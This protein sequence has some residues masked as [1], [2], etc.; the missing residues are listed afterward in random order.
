MFHVTDVDEDSLTQM[1][2]DSFLYERL[3]GGIELLS[4]HSADECRDSGG[5]V[6]HITVIY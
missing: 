1:F 4:L 2:G 6:I 5:L 3:W